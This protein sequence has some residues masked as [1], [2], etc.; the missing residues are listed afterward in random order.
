MVGAV[1]IGLITVIATVIIS[2]A[3]PMFRDTAAAVTLELGAGAGVGT[4]SLVTPVAAI[5]ICVTPPVDVDASPIVTSKLCEGE[6]SRIGARGGFV[7]SI[8]TIV[9]QITCP[10]VGNTPSVCAGKLVWG[11]RPG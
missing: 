4:A 9:I 11:T 10:G 7:R 8:A 2:I 3:G 6:T 1:G 5:V